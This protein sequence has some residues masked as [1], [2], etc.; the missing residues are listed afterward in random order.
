[1]TKI[2]LHLHSNHSNDGEFPPHKLVE[3]CLDAGITHAAISDHN[4]VRAVADAQRAAEGTS[5]D[6]I[7]AIELD[8]HFGALILHVLGYGV[9]PEASIFYDI[10][11]DIL[12]QERKN[13]AELIRQVRGLGFEFDDD[14]LA[15]LSFH[16]MISGEMIAEAA[17]IFDH[18]EKN[19]LLD[20][21]RGTGHR[22]DN[23]YVNFYW[24]YCGPGRQAYVPLQFINLDEAI[25]V[26]RSNGGVPILAHPGIYLNE[27]VQLLNNILAEGVQ[28]VE[29]YSSYHTPEQTKFYLDAVRAAGALITCGSDFHGKTKKSIKIGSV[30]CDGQDEEIISALL[31]RIE[32]YQ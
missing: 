14:F 28:G 5:L 26:V 18:E 27:D 21:Y 29:V 11:R 22:S 12:E 31:E 10:E 6:I 4:S 19:P 23:P 24:D 7:P 1:M 20:P 3:L 13:S 9:D 25:E 17:L 15:S 16:G 32:T 8:C 2:D 30:D